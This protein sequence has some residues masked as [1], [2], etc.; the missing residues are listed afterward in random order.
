MQREVHIRFP[1][2]SHK[3]AALE[4]ARA[5]KRMGRTRALRNQR[6]VAQLAGKE[7][8]FWDVFIPSTVARRVGPA[9]VLVR[10]GNSLADRVRFLEALH[11]TKI[12]LP[13]N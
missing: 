9:W 3:Q 1:R 4:L 12:E 7:R 2:L 6:R 13:H 5:T 11:V 8:T 10:Y